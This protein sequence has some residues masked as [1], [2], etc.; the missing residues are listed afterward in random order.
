MSLVKYGSY[1]NNVYLVIK[2][3]SEI[4]MSWQKIAATKI[5]LINIQRLFFL[6]I[7]GAGCAYPPADIGG[8]WYALLHIFVKKEAL[9]YR[10]LKT[11]NHRLEMNTWK[12][13][14]NVS[15][16]I[17]R[18]DVRNGS[19]SFEHLL[20]VILLDDQEWKTKGAIYE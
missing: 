10:M 4:P 2:R 6:G 1:F 12:Y 16:P 7:F 9:A 15:T 17:W 14:K 13:V 20:E 5:T 8:D 11:N 18:F 3:K 19:F